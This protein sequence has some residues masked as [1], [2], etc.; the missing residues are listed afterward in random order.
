QPN[1]DLAR[2]MREELWELHAQ[3]VAATTEKNFKLWNQ[4]M[5]ANWRQQRKDEPLV[6][7]LLRFW[8]V[9]TPYSPGL[10]VD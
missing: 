10:T 3:K 4:K 7:N 1:P 8:D 5:D 2:A 9:V 6:A